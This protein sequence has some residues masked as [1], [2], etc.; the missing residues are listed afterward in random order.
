[1]RRVAAVLT[2][3]MIAVASPAFAQSET[4]F[5]W[6]RFTAAQQENR[7]ILIHIAASWCPTCAAQERILSQLT[8]QPEFRK[9]IL[10]RVS[11][12]HQ[13]DVVRYFHATAQ[14]T[15]ITFRGKKEID[16]SLGDTDQDSIRDMLRAA[17]GS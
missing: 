10:L 12:D 3:L 13:K 14:S 6:Q 15:L 17:I 2:L 1:M 5:T 9:L 11:F 4:P 16:F 8:P 7:P